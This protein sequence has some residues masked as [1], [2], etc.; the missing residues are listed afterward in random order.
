V[1]AAAKREMIWRKKR[2]KEKKIRKKFDSEAGNFLQ[3]FSGWEWFKISD[4][5]ING[6]V[7]RERDRQT[8][9]D[10]DREMERRRKKKKRN[11]ERGGKEE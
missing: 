10:R 8:D 2:E 6:E 1:I 7:E 4:Y 5:G 9:R 3:I 11:R